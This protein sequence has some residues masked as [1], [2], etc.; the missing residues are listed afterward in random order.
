MLQHR[1]RSE[2]DRHRFPLV[3][4]R[5]G[6]TSLGRLKTGDIAQLGLFT[7]TGLQL[8]REE[9]FIIDLIYIGRYTY[10]FFSSSCDF[11]ILIVNS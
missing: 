3:C 8:R 2:A 4:G 5:P 6:A 1:S 10:L 9:R 7:A 11:E